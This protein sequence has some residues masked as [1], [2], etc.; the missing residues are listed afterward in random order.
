MANMENAA[1]KTRQKLQEAEEEKEVNEVDSGTPADET[2]NEAPPTDAAAECEAVKAENAQLREELEHLSSLVEEISRQNGEQVVQEMTEPTLNWEELA[3]E[4]PETVRARMAE[5]EEA[6]KAAARAEAE[7][8]M[9]ARMAPILEEMRTHEAAI[10]EEAML[11]RMKESPAMPG[12]AEMLPRVDAF[13]KQNGALYSGVSPQEAY[14]NAYLAQ[15]GYDAIQASE[16]PDEEA[17]LRYYEETPS[18][19]KRIEEVRLKNKENEAPLP[20]FAPSRGF[21]GAALTL[22]QKP[23]TFEDARRMAAGKRTVTK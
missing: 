5:Y 7:S 4:D 8:E 16:G 15:K 22:P 18:F 23:K 3:F 11:R 2:A 1:K 13:V 17:M 10:K 21:G 19:Q 14:V 12:F 9:E 20:P 6:V